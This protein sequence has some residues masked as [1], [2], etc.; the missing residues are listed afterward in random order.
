LVYR[1]IRSLD[2]DFDKALDLA[3]DKID[4]MVR[5]VNYNDIRYILFIN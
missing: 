1:A 5:E 4:K 3:A 2:G